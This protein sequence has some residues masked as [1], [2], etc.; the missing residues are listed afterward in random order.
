MARGR[1]K[2]TEFTRDETMDETGAPT[3]FVEEVEVV[4]KPEPDR[5]TTNFCEQ[6]EAIGVLKSLEGDSSVEARDKRK[7]ARECLNS[8]HSCGQ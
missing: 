7:A 4:E 3:V 6:C 5:G 1:K 8:A 2:K